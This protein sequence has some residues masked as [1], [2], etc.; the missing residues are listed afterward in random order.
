VLRAV[1]L[2]GRRYET[3][4]TA[5]AWRDFL[6]RAWRSLTLAEP[7]VRKH[8]MRIAIENHKDWRVPELLEVL[9]RLGSEHVGVCVDIGN[10][11]A[12]L[13]NPMDVVEAYAPHAFT[14]HLKDMGVQEYQDGFLLSEVP[15]GEGFL[16]LPKIIATL[17]KANSRIHFNLEMITRDPLEIPCLTKRYWSSM[18]GVSG[19]RL[20]ETLAMVRANVSKKPLPHVTGLTQDQKIRF[21]E[22]NVQKSFA[23]ARSHLGM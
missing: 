8:R 16:D 2:E 15:M 21:E 17:Q 19:G 18:E 11:I 4:E 10:S 23:F 5:Q 12:L 9:K 1:C 3:I 14:S 7:V 6:D 22:E 20:A 13:E